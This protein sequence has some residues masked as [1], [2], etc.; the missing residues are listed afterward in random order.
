MSY[1]KLKFF[2]M[3]ILIA[4]T[5]SSFSAT[6]TV[7]E[8]D[9]KLISSEKLVKLIQNFLNDKGIDSYPSIDKNK[10]FKNCGNPL[11]FFPVLGSWNTIE[12]VCSHPQKEWNIYVRT[13]A[14]TSH[15][16]REKNNITKKIIVANKSLLKGQ[17]INKKDL[18][19]IDAKKNIGI[20]IFNN[21]EDLIGRKLKHNVSIGFPLRSRHLH[22]DWLI[23][24]GDIV[25]IVQ[26]VGTVFISVSGIAL[27]NG[28]KGEK[29]RVKNLSSEKNLVAWVIDEK[30]VSIQTKIN[31]N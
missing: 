12:I 5:T 30:K 31:I 17:V 14:Q 18:K 27:D 16:K 9:N 20:G 29:I 3:F 21:I 2:I 22:L 6:K 24:K 7:I 10:K 1:F 23:K 25:D 4:T 26:S 13:R 8:D 19:L 28:Q 11:K 15:Q